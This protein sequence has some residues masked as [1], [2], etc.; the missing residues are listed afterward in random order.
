MWQQLTV[1]FA[2]IGDKCKPTGGDFFGF[3]KWYKYLGGVEESGGCAPRLESL[4]DI[5]KVGAA[6]LEML[7][8]LGS[9]LAVIFIIWGAFSLITAQGEPE[10]I[11]SGKETITN[12]IV[13]LLVTV[14]AATIVSVVAGRL[15]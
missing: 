1:Y 4:P 5:W 7:L 15:S 8:R 13:G 3:P 12:A 14:L 9:L 6:I 10:R 11:K 2:A